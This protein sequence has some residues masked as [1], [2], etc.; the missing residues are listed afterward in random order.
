VIQ[1]PWGREGRLSRPDKVQGDCFGGHSAGN[2]VVAVAVA[3]VATAAAAAAALKLADLTKGIG[4]D[5]PDGGGVT[6]FVDKLDIG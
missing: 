2:A 4:S 3:A 1:D 5:R 6:G